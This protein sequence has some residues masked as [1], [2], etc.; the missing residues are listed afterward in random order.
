MATY[1]VYKKILKKEWTLNLQVAPSSYDIRRG[2]LSL[3]EFRTLA[4]EEK[5]NPYRLVY[6]IE[7]DYVRR[8][9]FEILL[10]NINYSESSDVE[11]LLSNI[12]EYIKKS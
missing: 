6:N 10:R 9:Q 7:G 3:E 12:F 2:G 1:V 8:G 11:T 4:V 5:H